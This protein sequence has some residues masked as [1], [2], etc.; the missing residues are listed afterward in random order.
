MKKNCQLL[1]KALFTISLL[2]LVLS[3]CSKK[4][5]FNPYATSNPFG[6]KSS[7]NNNNNTNRSSNNNTNNNSNSSNKN[8]DSTPSGQYSTNLNFQYTPGSGVC[9]VCAVTNALGQE[10]NVVVPPTYTDANGN[11]YQVE[12]D[13]SNGF[14]TLEKTKTITF[15]NGFKKL[16]VGF[17]SSLKLEKIVLPASL[18]RIKAR[19]L[20]ACTSFKTIEYKGTKEQWNAVQKL[21]SWNYMAPEFVVS[22][23]D[24]NITVP[25]YVEED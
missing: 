24:G 13:Y 17:G 12:G 3:G 21:E 16:D 18:E 4:E 20:V 14:C 19:I 8:N 25:L 2:T 15:S 11:T 9:N 1:G 6:N 10:E 7:Q 23:S 22:C 5:G